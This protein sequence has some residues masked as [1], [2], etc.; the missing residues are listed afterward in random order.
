M[1]IGRA[2]CYGERCSVCRAMLDR[3]VATRIY[4]STREFRPDASPGLQRAGEPGADF[5]KFG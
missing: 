5:R 3:R 1:V 4:S 2:V